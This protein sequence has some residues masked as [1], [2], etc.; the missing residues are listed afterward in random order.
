MKFWMQQTIQ[1]LEKSPFRQLKLPWQRIHLFI[2]FYLFILQAFVTLC[3]AFFLKRLSFF[4][5]VPRTLQVSTGPRSGLSS[6]VD[7]Q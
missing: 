2:L 5:N 7:E 6:V 4:K 1:F 3:Y